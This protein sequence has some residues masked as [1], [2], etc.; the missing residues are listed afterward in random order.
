MSVGKAPN[1]L[2]L[3]PKKA[4]E[5]LLRNSRKSGTEYLPWWWIIIMKVIKILPVQFISKL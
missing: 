4:V 5:I 1:F 2:Y 3:S